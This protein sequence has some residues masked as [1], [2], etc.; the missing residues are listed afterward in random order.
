[1]AAR[2]RLLETG[3]TSGKEL[4]ETVLEVCGRENL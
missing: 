2:K 1:M 3:Y 4:V